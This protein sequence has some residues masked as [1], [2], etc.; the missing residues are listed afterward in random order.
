MASKSALT[1]DEPLPKILVTGAAGFLGQQVVR[2][3]QAA[4]AQ[5]HAT[6][7]RRDGLPV[8]LDFR[9]ADICAP[10]TL[11]GT[12][13]GIDCVVHLAGLAHVFGKSRAVVAPFHK[14]NTAGTAHVARAA[15]EAGVRAFVL[16][17]SVSV[18]G[19]HDAQP[20]DE[21]FPCYPETPYAESKY[22][23]EKRA[24]EIAK[25]AGMRLT[26]LR[27]ATLYGEG[28]PGN[29]AR[30]FRAIDRR[31][32]VWIG[33]GSN[34]K[35]LIHREDAAKACVTAAMS[36]MGP[37]GEVRTYNVAAPPCT[38]RQIVETIADAL[39]RRLP[40]WRVPAAMA[41][42]GSRVA[43]MLMF[44][45]TRLGGLPDTLRKWLAE[46]TYAGD[47]FQRAFHFQPE[48]S[49]AEGIRR[50]AN[51]FRQSATVHRV[52][53]GQAHFSAATAEK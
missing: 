13:A 30:L 17:S 36:A 42:H 32:F 25:A 34:R 43:S 9:Q 46:D 11:R 6:D 50:E 45:R 51:W 27:L 52:R 23:A 37:A 3:A 20:V 16:V 4:G 8:D 15:A 26:I 53:R 41:V 18:Y 10:E 21:S 19:R 29:V 22:D 49:L 40:T 24:T 39:S 2:C 14:V 31:R 35:S 5:V 48:V 44:G 47:R 28:D 12:F 38:M 1:A 7:R 33:D